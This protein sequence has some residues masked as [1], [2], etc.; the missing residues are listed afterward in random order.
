MHGYL[1]ADNI[2]SEK[3]TVFWEG[4]S[5]TTVSFEEQ[6]TSKDKFARPNEGYACLLSF[7]YFSQRLKFCIFHVFK[8]IARAWKYLMDYNWQYECIPHIQVIWLTVIFWCSTLLS[9][10]Y[11][12]ILRC[13][14]IQAWTPGETFSISS[15]PAYLVNIVAIHT[16]YQ[17]HEIVADFL[18]QRT[19]AE[20]QFDES[21]QEGSR[22]KIKSHIRVEFLRKSIYACCK[23]W[24]L[25]KVYNIQ[26]VMLCVAV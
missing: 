24:I 13:T 16:D 26:V 17:L 10:L 9:H 14:F 11:T 2:C 22:K 8:P 12:T 1:S 15:P 5:R 20:A 23:F 4:S 18:G 25:G 6:L 3:R 21:S 19:S 7:K